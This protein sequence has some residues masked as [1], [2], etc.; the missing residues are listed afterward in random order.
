MYITEEMIRIVRIVSTRYPNRLYILSPILL[1]LSVLEFVVG[2][3]EMM[4]HVFCDLEESTVSL[5]VR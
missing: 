1:F 3:I 2:D 4:R 5:S